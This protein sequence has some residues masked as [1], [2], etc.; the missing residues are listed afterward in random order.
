MSSVLR[1]FIIALSCLLAVAIAVAGFLAGWL[2]SKP[3]EKPAAQSSSSLEESFRGSASAAPSDLKRFAATGRVFDPLDWNPVDQNP[4]EISPDPPLDNREAYIAWMLEHT[5]EEEYFI[6]WRWDCVQDL[7]KWSS[8]QDK[9]V[10]A[11]F[12][13]TPREIFIRKHNKSRAYEHSY[14]PIGF[15]STI[16]DPWVVSVM[17]QTINPAKH[18]RVLEIGTGSGYQSALLAHLTDHVYTLEIN[19]A[20]ADETDQ[21]FRA[22]EKQYPEYS[23]IRRKSADGYYGWAEHAPYQ[24][25]LVTCS[26]DH[27]PPFLLKQLSPEGSMVIPV[28]PPSGQTLMKI[29]KSVSDQGDISYERQ[30][31]MS[32][33]F[34]PFRSKSGESY[35]KNY[36]R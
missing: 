24:G 5:D 23:L 12:L 19:E 11:A 26:I 6:R 2:S 21:L 31:I 14:M 32:V 27:V 30:S 34:I 35:S 1:I 17:T 13:R 29:T 15:G 7:V 16:T 4:Q 8:I 25:I 9:R 3:M 33:R 20:L 36:L 18:H 10:L 22:L 28:G